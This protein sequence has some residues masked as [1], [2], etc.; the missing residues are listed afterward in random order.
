MPSAEEQQVEL[1]N[2]VELYIKYRKV[3]EDA[4]K[5]VATYDEALLEYVP[6]VITKEVEDF[7]SLLQR[8]KIKM[9]DLKG[10]FDQAFTTDAAQL[11]DQRDKIE[12][13]YKKIVPP[14]HSLCVELE[15]LAAHVKGYNWSNP[16][17]RGQYNVLKVAEGSTTPLVAR[18]VKDREA[19]IAAVV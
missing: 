14:L 10:P 5:T 19:V 1:T 15:V 18:L 13:I 11:K 6:P 4:R 7:L 9:A 12:G 3:R 8:S 16:L 2:K 17:H